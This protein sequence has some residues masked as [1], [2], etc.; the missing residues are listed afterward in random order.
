MLRHT[1]TLGVRLRSWERRTLSRSVREEDGVRRKSG[2]GYGVKKEKIE[3]E[4][5]AALARR[6]GISLFEAR[7]RLKK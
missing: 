6:E 5:L 1:T 3:F 7:S 2:E 4:D